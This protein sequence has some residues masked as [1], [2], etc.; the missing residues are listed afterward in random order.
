MPKT[1]VQTVKFNAPPEA[2]YAL[3]TDSRKH[4]EA[5]GVK[6]VMSTKIGGSCGAWNGG[7]KGITLGVVRNDQADSVLAFFFEKDGKGGKVTMVHANIPDE[8]YPGIKTGWTTYYWTPWKK[9]IA[10]HGN[11]KKSKS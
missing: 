6:A 11:G 4:S 10:N 9:Y 1:I 3:Y 5:T 7:L 2:L 8:H